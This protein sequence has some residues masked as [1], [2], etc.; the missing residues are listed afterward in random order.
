MSRNTLCRKLGMA[1]LTLETLW[2]VVPSGFVVSAA[3]PQEK[4]QSQS[5]QP[6]A[7]PS[8][9]PSPSAQPASDL[10]PPV[11]ALPVKRRKV[12][13]N[14]EVVLLRT[15][16]DDY[17]AEKEAK[18]VAEGEAAAKSTAKSKTTVAATT[19]SKL[20]TSIEETQLLIKNKEQDITDDQASLVSLNAEM[21]NTPDEQKKSKQ[22]EIEIV[23]AELDRARN[24]LKTLQDHLADLQKPPAGESTAPPPPPPN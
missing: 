5:Q 23:A 2:L 9:T 7:P 15:P 18:R 24:E 21:A 12:W 17:L 13:T 22:K 1:L 8:P 16:A 6:P 11:G 14:D 3:S 4:Q 10:A 19:E 20:P